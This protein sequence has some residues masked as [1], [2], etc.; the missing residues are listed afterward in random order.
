AGRKGLAAGRVVPLG[1]TE[2][3]RLSKLAVELHEERFLA[4][5]GFRIAMRGL[6]AL[7]AVEVARLAVGRARGAAEAIALEPTGAT[8]DALRKLVEE[9]FHKERQLAFYAD[10]LAMTV[11]RLN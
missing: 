5:A 2:R 11:A 10:K 7:I 4:R 6:L 1:E 9:H 3:D 8:V